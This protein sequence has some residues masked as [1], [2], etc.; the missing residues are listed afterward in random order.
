M[1]IFFAY[2]YLYEKSFKGI[3]HVKDCGSKHKLI[4]KKQSG[5]DRK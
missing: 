5:G 1:S 2:G 3:V 4:I